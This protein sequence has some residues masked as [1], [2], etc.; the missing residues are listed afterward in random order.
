MEVSRPTRAVVDLTAFSR[1]LRRVR[2]YVGLDV[3]ILAVVKGDGYGHG[4]AEVARTAI[5]AGAR[6]LGV[7]IPEEGILLRQA[8]LKVPI[9]VMGPTTPLQASLVVDASL[10]QMVCTLHSAEVLSQ[11]ASSRGKRVGIHLKVD[12]GMS[13]VGVT[14]QEMLPF[15]RALQKLPGVDL[16]G[17]MGHI[18]TADSPL[19]HPG[20]SVARAQIAQ[21]WEVEHTLREA[22]ISLPLRHLANSAAVVQHP[23]AHADLVRPGIILYGYSPVKGKSSRDLGLVPVLSLRSEIAALRE[24]EPGTGVSYGRTFVATQRTRVATVP[25]GY[26]DGYSVRLSNVGQVLVHGRR[27]PVIGRVCM[28]MLMVDVTALSGV[29]VG[30]EV[31]LY[32]RQGEEEVTVEEVAE[33]LGTISYEVLCAVGKRVPRVYLPA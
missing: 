32:G 11:L 27:V 4:A 9:L 5:T 28:D 24:I 29:A 23:R 22:G 2:E 14:P 13:R 8:G 26:A 15:A 31:V 1:N 19:D 33:R 16:R 12:I 25:I 6:W 18:A 20:T 21:F 10:D 7:A 3:L 30:D 17:L